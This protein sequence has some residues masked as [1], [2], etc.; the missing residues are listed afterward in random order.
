MQATDRELAQ[1]QQQVSCVYV[2]GE[3]RERSYM[4]V[5][6][7]LSAELG[8]A[9]VWAA[10]WRHASHSYIKYM[11]E[12]HTQVVGLAPLAQSLLYPQFHQTV[13]L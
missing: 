12:C 1:A 8:Q 13:L 6:C 2:W 9:F 4:G 7:M 10:T 5:V 11:H 3:G